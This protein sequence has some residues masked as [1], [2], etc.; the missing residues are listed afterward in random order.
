MLTPALE[1]A[2]QAIFASGDVP[3]A[4]ALLIENTGPGSFDLSAEANERIAA[5][6]LKQS[7]G[8]IPRLRAATELARRDWRDLLVAAGFGNDL[9]A[10][11]AWLTS[12]PAKV[13]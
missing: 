9:S 8:S 10:H 6:M 4:R 7:N 1:H 2:L 13:R 5:A 12:I 3:T 11:D